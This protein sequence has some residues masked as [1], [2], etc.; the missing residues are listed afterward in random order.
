MANHINQLNLVMLGVGAAFDFHSGKV[1]QSPA[2]MQQL[3]L[4]W[5]FRLCV[6]PKRLWKR[7]FYHNPRFLFYFGVQYCR[8]LFQLTRK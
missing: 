2:W 1:K 3:S 6:E 4:E 7:Y 8:Q 5:L